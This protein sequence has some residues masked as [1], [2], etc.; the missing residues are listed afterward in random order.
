M[1]KICSNIFIVI[2]Y[3]GLTPVVPKPPEA[4]VLPVSKG[5]SDA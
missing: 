3:V 2:K 4:S 5:L 1:L